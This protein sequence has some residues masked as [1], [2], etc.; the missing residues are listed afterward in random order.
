MNLSYVLVFSSSCQQGMDAPS[1]P[2]LGG[3]RVS[4]HSLCIKQPFLGVL[5]CIVYS[6]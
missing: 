6:W 1:L 2:W 5:K 3:V 4:V